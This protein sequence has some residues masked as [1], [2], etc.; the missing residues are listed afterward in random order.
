MKLYR[1]KHRRIATTWLNQRAV[2]SYSPV[3]DR[4]SLSLIKALFEESQEGLVPINPQVSVFYDPRVSKSKANRTS[5]MLAVAHLT[6]W[7]L[8][9]SAS[10]LTAS[11]ILLSVRL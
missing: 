8:L 10:A 2:D 3:L 1:R 5:L 4:E 11:N 9:L 6:T 7:P